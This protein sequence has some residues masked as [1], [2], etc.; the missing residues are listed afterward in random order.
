V[1]PKRL[2]RGSIQKPILPATRNLADADLTQAVLATFSNAGSGRF[3][4]IMQSLV[5]HL[6]AFVKDVGLTE[7]EWFK[8]IE[9]LTRTGHNT[10]DKRQEFILLSD[11]LGVSM[12]VIGLNNKKPAGATASTVFGPFFVDGSP[13]FANGDDIANGCALF[14]YALRLPHGSCWGE[15]CAQ[16]VK[17]LWQR[18]PNT[19]GRGGRRERRQRAPSTRRD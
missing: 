18:L 8:G 11:V 16:F 17:L 12:L 4:E 14:Y 3:Q 19:H 7:E 6:H 1:C 13:R 9:Y 5:R 10:D 2:I 15:G